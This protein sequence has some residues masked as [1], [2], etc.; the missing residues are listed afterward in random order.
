MTRILLRR[1]FVF[2]AA[3]L[4]SVATADTGF[5][6]RSVTIGAETYRYVVY[7]PRTWT[8]AEKWPVIVSLHGNGSQGADGSRHLSGGSVA[9][10]VAATLADRDH[11]PALVLFP[12]ARPQTRWSAP[13]MEEMVM[14][15]IDATMREFNGDA[16]RLYFLSHSMGA[17]G[18]LRIAA[19]WPERFAGIVES[20]GA[21]DA[22]G[23][24]D[25]RA[26]SYLN[27]PDPFAAIAAIIRS[28]PI[29]IVH[30]DSDQEVAV[31]RSRR[32]AAA[33]KAVGANVR[34]TVL[35]G[36]SHEETAIKV[37]NDK[38]ILGWLLAQHRKD[39]AN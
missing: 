26:H 20:A 19:R 10:L 11:V 9:A 15:A 35:A 22:V 25:R 14:T 34:Y 37:A 28:I 12:Q 23:Q 16:D 8:H 18:A 2:I 1:S 31:E 30:S 4:P 5:L 29:W 13:A 33:L 7:V 27:E 6:D 24:E 17:Q 36:V 3:L 21:P 39:G 32:L 38:E